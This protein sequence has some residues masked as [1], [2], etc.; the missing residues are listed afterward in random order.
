MSESQQAM[1]RLNEFHAVQLVKHSLNGHYLV[2]RPVIPL[3]RIQSALRPPTCALIGWNWLEMAGNDLRVLEVCST[4]FLEIYWEG[5][6][7]FEMVSCGWRLMDAF[8]LVGWCGCQS[9]RGECC[10]LEGLGYKPDL[11]V[12][13]QIIN[14]SEIINYE[15]SKKMQSLITRL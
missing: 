13:C 3:A 7:A 14:L 2:I 10:P 5:R 4:L 15:V 9:G 12:I 11:A 1:T 8:V 6:H